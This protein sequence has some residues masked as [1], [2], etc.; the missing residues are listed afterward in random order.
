MK[1]NRILALLIVLLFASCENEESIMREF[2]LNSFSFSDCKHEKGAMIYNDEL[3]GY[4]Y[5]KGDLLYFTHQNVA[6][7]CCQPE[8]NL[9]VVTSLVGD[10]I[11]INEFEKVPGLCKCI[12]PYDMECKVGPLKEK[13]YWIIVKTGEIESFRFPIYFDEELDGVKSL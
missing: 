1:K 4:R 12:C 9:T 6:F 8:D 7:N 2:S 13:Q 10:S 11:I 3:V 5:E